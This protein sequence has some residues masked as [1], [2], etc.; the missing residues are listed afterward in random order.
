MNRYPMVNRNTLLY[1]ITRDLR[2]ANSSQTYACMKTASI[3]DTLLYYFARDL[4][5]ANSS[6]T[7]ACMKTASIKDTLLYYFTRD[8]R[9]ANS[10]QTYACM[11]TASIKD[12]Q[13]F[14]LLKQEI[15]VQKVLCNAFSLCL[16]AIQRNF[17]IRNCF[18]LFFCRHKINKQC[19][20]WPCEINKTFI[21]KKTSIYRTSKQPFIY[22]Y[23][24]NLRKQKQEIVK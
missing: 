18:V 5:K 12:T 8:L 4:R 23:I 24:C 22:I 2:K 1:Y 13:C 15:F 20:I 11:K 16:K 19:Y 17:E 3:K 9:K 14:I 21:S 10:S 7:Y 6:Q